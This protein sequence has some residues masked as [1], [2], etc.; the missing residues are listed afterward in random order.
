MKRD[1]Q[2]K[3]LMEMLKENIEKGDMVDVMNFAAMI[4][5]RTELYGD[6]A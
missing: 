1:L 5:V 3:T 6:D 4:Y 2:I